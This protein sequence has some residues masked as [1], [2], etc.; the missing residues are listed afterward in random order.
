MKEIKFRKYGNE[1][2]HGQFVIH[3]SRHRLEHWKSKI[4]TT[5]LVHQHFAHLELT[6]Q[7]TCGIIELYREFDCADHPQLVLSDGTLCNL[8]SVYN[9][10]CEDELTYL[11]LTG[12]EDESPISYSREPLT[13]RKLADYIFR[14]FYGRELDLNDPEKTLEM[15]Y[16]WNVLMSSLRF[17]R[18][19]DLL[20]EL[21]CYRSC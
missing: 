5:N 18:P 11:L 8:H 9:S 4:F 19:M 15:E 17:G 2:D 16:I 10:F 3:F 12:L 20:G 7:L 1:N 21:I 6:D 13:A 14:K